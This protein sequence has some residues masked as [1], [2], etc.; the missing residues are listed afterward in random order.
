MC[1]SLPENHEGRAGPGRRIFQATPL[2]TKRNI[3]CNHQHPPNDAAEKVFLD[4]SPVG[5][6]NTSGENSLSN[7]NMPSSMPSPPASPPKHALTSHHCYTSKDQ[8][9]AQARITS[10]PNLLAWPSS[11]HTDS[12]TMMEERPLSNSERN[13]QQLHLNKPA[14]TQAPK[15]VRN[16]PSPT[17]SLAK[18][19]PMQR[20]LSSGCLTT[21]IGGCK[22]RRMQLPDQQYEI[23]DTRDGQRPR[24]TQPLESKLNPILRRSARKP[25]PSQSAAQK[26]AIGTT[27]QT[28]K[29][30]PRS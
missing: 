6:E 1:R 13:A 29:R 11:G 10:N 21:A 20:V 30:T 17:T 19:L 26:Q 4:S 7:T 23:Q 2:S 9:T 18:N 15:L 16:V 14:N 3:F 25:I 28:M 27:T 5:G 12:R 8:G 22:R 24:S